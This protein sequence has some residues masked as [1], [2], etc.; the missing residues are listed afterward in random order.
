[1]KPILLFIAAAVLASASL[2][3]A[4]VPCPTSASLSTLEAF[5]TAADACYSQDKLFWGFNYTP[6]A[7]AP[8]ATD[9]TASLIQQSSPSLDVHGWNFDGNWIQTG[10]DLASFVMGYTTEFCSASPCTTGNPGEYISGADAT[11]APVSVLPTGNEDVSWSNGAAVTLTKGSPGP[12]PSNGDIGLTP[13]F[14][15]PI[16]V[17]ADFAGTGGITQT[18][19]RFF[20]TTP[21]MSTV[22]EPANLGL[23]LGLAGLAIAFGAR[24]MKR[25]AA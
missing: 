3:A 23:F 17:S 24:R 15:G 18:S 13:S 1:M 14:T 21:S 5:D 25:G 11:Y 9:V 10:S 12:L 16:S 8:A 2:S 7:A 20:E 6:G 19:L 22:P 4:V